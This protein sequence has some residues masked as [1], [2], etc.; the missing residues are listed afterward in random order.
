M[1]AVLAGIGWG[2]AG[3]LAV[4]LTVAIVVLV[5]LWK[6]TQAQTPPAQEGRG[7][8]ADFSGFGRQRA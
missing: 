6:R 4:A 8:V 1:N 5:A 3:G 2:L 7:D